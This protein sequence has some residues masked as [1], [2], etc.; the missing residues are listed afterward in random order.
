MPEA[1]FVAGF[2]RWLE[3]GRHVRKGEKA[4]GILAPLAYRNKEEAD[5][6]GEKPVSDER[7]ED[8]AGVG[9]RGRIV[10]QRFVAGHW[11]RAS[12]RRC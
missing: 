8:R 4:I 10:G 6:P 5:D 7:V 2:R 1:S 12:A 11:A 3:L 9:G